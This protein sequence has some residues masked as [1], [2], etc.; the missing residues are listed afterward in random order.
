V[1]GPP[2]AAARAG[3]QHDRDDGARTASSS[4]SVRRHHPSLA[5]IGTPGARCG[6]RAGASEDD[7]EMTKICRIDVV[8]THIA[9]S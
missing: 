9:I 8:S 7:E 6:D 4:C 1:R 3:G 2:E 5:Q